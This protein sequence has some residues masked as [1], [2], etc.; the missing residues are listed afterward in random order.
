MKIGRNDPCHCGSGKKYKHCHYEADL[1]QRRIEAEQAAENA[2]T[3]EDAPDEASD[4]NEHD[5]SRKQPFDHRKDRSR[6]QGD[7]RGGGANFKPRAMR[8]AQ[9]GS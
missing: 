7:V 1:E 6:F 2:P 9:R 4:S 3:P 8:G 5:A